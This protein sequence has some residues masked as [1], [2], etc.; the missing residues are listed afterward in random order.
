MHI[1]DAQQIGIHEVDI[2]WQ[3]ADRLSIP[4]QQALEKQLAGL[5][6]WVEQ[7]AELVYPVLL[8]LL[9]DFCSFSGVQKTLRIALPQLSHGWDHVG[10]LEELEQARGDLDGLDAKVAHLQ[11]LLPL[12]M[13]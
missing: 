3:G 8:L 13:W 11:L 10:L 12:Q 4:W 6:P 7:V 9:R 2:P 1:V 5:D